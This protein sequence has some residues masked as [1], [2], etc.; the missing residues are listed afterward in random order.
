[1][2]IL[3]LPH[4]VQS[5]NEVGIL[6]DTQW[7]YTILDKPIT[8][9]AQRRKW[10]QATAQSLLEGQL[11]QA[12]TIEH[13]PTGRPYIKEYPEHKISISHTNQ[14]VIILYTETKKSIAIDIE[15]MDRDLKAV[16][17]HF[18][19]ESE[20]AICQKQTNPSH[21][22]LQL[23]SAKETLFKFLD[24][25]GLTLSQFILKDISHS[26]IPHIKKL[27]LKYNK[28]TYDIYACWIDGHICTFMEE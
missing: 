22:F 18:C 7:L 9:R 10:E 26:Q 15:R 25:K 23:W 16:T 1:M 8:D 17:K 21:A 20:Q 27:T 24:V 4:L 6:Q 3:S 13:Y 11:Q 5:L 28:H 12:V 2:Y 19:K 14:A